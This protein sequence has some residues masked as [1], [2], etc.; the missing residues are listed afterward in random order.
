MGITYLKTRK[1]PNIFL[2]LFGVRPTEFE[3]ICRAIEPLWEKEVLDRYKKI[4]RRYKLSVPE[5]V[6]MLLMYYRTYTTQL[7]IGFLFGLDDSRVCRILR[8]LEPIVA[9][10]MAIEKNRRLTPEE[11]TLLLD[12]TEQPIE[13]PKNNQG[14]YYSGKKKRHT[15]KTEIRVTQEG[16]IRSVSK[17]FAGKTHDFRI[18]KESDP[19]P[20]H[21]RVLADS[22]Y[23]GLKKRCHR[24]KI[25]YKKTKRNPLTH[26]QKLFNRAL[27][28]R[29]IKVENIFAQ[30]K[31]FRIL[32]DRYRNK[33]L[34]HNL[35]FNIIAGLVNFKN[36]FQNKHFLKTPH[37]NLSA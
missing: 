33:G 20:N 16:K 31:V 18:L 4:G 27:S 35:K 6:M 15:L 37:Y 11:V 36:G 5:M 26:R 34:R 32:S 19:L 12:V 10:V 2:R 7:Q 9:K 8:R 14:D 29:R 28:K 24:A 3:V 21:T 13:R 25:P 30:L 1:H 17:A 23:Q 22:G